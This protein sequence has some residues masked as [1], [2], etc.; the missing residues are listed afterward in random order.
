LHSRSASSQAV[1]V[2][3][4]L[5]A[6]FSLT[7]LFISLGRHPYSALLRVPERSEPDAAASVAHIGLVGLVYQI[8]S[9]CSSIPLTCLCRI[10]L[11]VAGFWQCYACCYAN[12]FSK[13]VTNSFAPSHQDVTWR[14]P[15]PIVFNTLIFLIPFLFICCPLI[16]L[17]L[18]GFHLQRASSALTVIL[19]GLGAAAREFN[20]NVPLD[21]SSLAEL[22]EPGN[23]Y[24]RETLQ[25]LGGVRLGYI[26]YTL[27]CLTTMTVRIT[28]YFTAFLLRNT[29]GN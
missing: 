10:P 5:H 11:T 13:S 9:S 12:G 17:A 14:A 23:V 8:P 22:A 7:L 28:G 2:P 21:L 3:S 27:S 1:R 25:S 18:A 29:S 4:L 16:P 15:P 6:C 19:E 20:P 26:F 24:V